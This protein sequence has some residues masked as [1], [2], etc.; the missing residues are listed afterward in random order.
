MILSLISDT[1]LSKFVGLSEQTNINP[2]EIATGASY[3]ST[4]IKNAV[5]S[6]IEYMQTVNMEG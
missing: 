6:A 5:N 3:S 2:G 1:G 4:A